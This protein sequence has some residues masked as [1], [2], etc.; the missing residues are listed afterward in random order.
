M[1]RQNPDA[2]VHKMRSL[3]HLRRELRDLD[4]TV[5]W[6]EAPAGVVAF[7]RGDHLFALNASDAA[8]DFTPGG[9]WSLIHR[10]GA[11][12]LERPVLTIHI[13]GS[14]TVTARNTD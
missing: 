9:V 13:E 7:R 6:L 10:T 3:L 1:Q 11:G 2:H 14:E 5:D 4:P 12:E 8:I